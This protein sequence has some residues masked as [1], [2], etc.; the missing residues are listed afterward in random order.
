M[1][2]PNPE[3]PDEPERTAATAPLPPGVRRHIGQNLRTF[4]SDALAAPAN[5]R[6]E[7]LIAQL[8]KPKR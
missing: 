6:L 1:S 8:A 4:Y 5:Q 2:K 7:A 3:R